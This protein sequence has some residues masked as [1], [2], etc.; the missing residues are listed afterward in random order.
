MCTS[1][2]RPNV[3]RSAGYCGRN[4]LRYG[5][6]QRVDAGPFELGAAGGGASDVLGRRRASCGPR[7][8]SELG[9]GH[10]TLGARARY[11]SCFAVMESAP[12]G[13]MVDRLGECGVIL[14]EDG[15]RMALKF[16]PYGNRMA[17]AEASGRVRRHRRDRCS[18]LAHAWHFFRGRALRDVLASTA[19]EPDRCTP[20]QRGTRTARRQSGACESLH[21]CAHGRA[22]LAAGFGA[23][24]GTD[25][26]TTCDIG[27]DIVTRSSPRPV[28]VNRTRGCG[29]GHQAGGPALARSRPA[30]RRPVTADRARGLGPP[31]VP[32]LEAT[33]GSRTNG[34]R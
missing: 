23:K 9:S 16:L 15:V 30:P 31:I 32:A 33:A 6:H 12:A 19:D 2:R 17:V 21:S 26:A 13:D 34:S 5:R 11:A 29:P 14:A 27:A 20:G 7:R 28:V 8:R 4:G 10:G 24:Y 18:L 1:S 25:V 22:E 3:C